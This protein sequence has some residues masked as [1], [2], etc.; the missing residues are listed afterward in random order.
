MATWTLQVDIPSFERITSGTLR[1]QARPPNPL[2]PGEDYAVAKA[3]D[4]LEF[5]AN[6]SKATFIVRRV[7]SYTTAEELLVYEDIR[8]VVPDVQSLKEAA[9]KINTKFG[10]AINEHGIV[11]IEIGE[12]I[13]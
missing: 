6:G 11:A 10:T 5:R 12:R 1:I 2:K 13:T 7:S 4:H 9:E 3:G 8:L